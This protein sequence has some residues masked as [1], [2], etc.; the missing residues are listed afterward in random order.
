MDDT[1]F[2]NFITPHLERVRNH[3]DGEFI[4]AGG[5]LRDTYLGLQPKDIDVFVPP[6]GLSIEELE[7][8][9]GSEIFHVK[10]LPGKDLNELPIEIITLS[11]EVPFTLEGVCDRFDLGICRIAINQAGICL[12]TQE[13][14]H[15]MLNSKITIHRLNGGDTS[16]INKRIDRMLGKFP[17]FSINDP[18]GLLNG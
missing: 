3:V 17:D 9:S 6:S 16:R 4:I 11:N 18:K 7:T 13:F 10:C 12:I 14:F 2:L 8:Y 5:F 1:Q 15:D